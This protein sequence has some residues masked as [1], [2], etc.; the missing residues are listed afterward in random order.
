MIKRS[1]ALLLTLLYTVTVM[2]FA[3]NLHYCCSQLT[4]LKINEQVKTNLTPS[5]K[6]KCCQTKHF[7]VKVKDAHQGESPSFLT[8]VFAFEL[9]KFAF[10]DFSFSMQYALLRNDLD[11]GPPEPSVDANIAF[12]KN[13]IFRI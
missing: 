13:R 5:C 7:E 4:L 11:R 12:L 8:K 3:F 10:A 2:G 1:G 9:P 6:M